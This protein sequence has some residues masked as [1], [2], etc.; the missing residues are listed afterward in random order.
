M[1]SEHK[2]S[3]SVGGF[4]E[5]FADLQINIPKSEMAKEISLITR[6][7]E[8]SRTEHTFLHTLLEPV[9]ER[10]IER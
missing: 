4:Y 1:G 6:G 7:K 2:Y 3:P 8:K 5:H 10:K 9:I